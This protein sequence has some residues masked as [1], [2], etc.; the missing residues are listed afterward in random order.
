MIIL[1][2]EKG[3]LKQWEEKIRDYLQYNKMGVYLLRLEAK[4]K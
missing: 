3:N 4:G 1:V 2:Q